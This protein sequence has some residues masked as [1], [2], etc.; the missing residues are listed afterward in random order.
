MSI[1]ERTVYT[2]ATLLTTGAYIHIN[3]T[4]NRSTHR[5]IDPRD[6]SKG[7]LD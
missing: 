4:A 2:V 5:A 1:E 7:S 3:V 6:V